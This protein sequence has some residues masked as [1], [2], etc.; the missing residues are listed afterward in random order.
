MT[1]IIKCL[2]AKQTINLASR[3]FS[4]YRVS[5]IR[6]Q[7][8]TH[9]CYVQRSPAVSLYVSTSLSQP[10]TWDSTVMSYA[11][12]T[13]FSSGFTSTKWA[14]LRFAPFSCLRFVG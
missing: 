7:M 6:F 1:I 13:R 14:A 5:R 10:L 12:E 2:Q 8:D 3:P 4:L 11:L 9:T